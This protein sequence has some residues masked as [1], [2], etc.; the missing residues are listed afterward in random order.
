MRKAS[1]LIPLLLLLAYAGGLRQS[2]SQPEPSPPLTDG[3][4][5]AIQVQG[6]TLGFEVFGLQ[7]LGDGSFAL[8]SSVSFAVG[9]QALVQQQALKLDGEFRPAFYAVKKSVLAP[10][11]G[12]LTAQAIV[13]DGTAQLSVRSPD[14]NEEEKTITSE[15]EFLLLDNAVISHGVA[16]IQ[17]MVQLQTD[18]LNADLLIPQSLAAQTA[19]ITREGTVP[20]RT[21]EGTAFEAVEYRIV[22]QV[23]EGQPVPVILLFALN[24]RFIA[25]FQPR[26]E[27]SPETFAFRSDLFPEGLEPPEAP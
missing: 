16:I 5:L 2:Q 21:T 25:T 22:G 17:R 20:L 27:D 9:S 18:R 26:R 12:V 10:D 11:S 4:T 15:R 13:Q 6:Q 14:G 3:G 8:F 19:T 1:F 7:Q 24:D 23:S